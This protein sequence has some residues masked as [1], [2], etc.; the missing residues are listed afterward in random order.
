V[1]LLTCLSLFGREPTR[2]VLNIDP[3]G[4]IIELD[5][6]SIWRV[7]S[8]S[9]KNV[10]NYFDYGDEVIIYPVLFP[11]MS[12]SSLYFYNVTKQV[13]ANVELSL[14]P[15]ASRPFHVV[16]SDIDYRAGYVRIIDNSGI[17]AVW[18]IATQDLTKF[19]NWDVGDSVMLGSNLN[20][21]RW[22]GSRDQ[23][24]LINASKRNFVQAR[25]D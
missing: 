13:S 22:F 1:L 19:T 21:V 2:E 25:A 20:Y 24:I 14:G 12:S 23:Y 16:I 3:S 4:Y 8:G 6:G 9:T 15:V 18:R 17:S 11:A 10:K 7:C 5:D